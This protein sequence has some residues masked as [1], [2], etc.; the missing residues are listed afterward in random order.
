MGLL[1]FLGKKNKDSVKPSSSSA[2]HS[3]SQ[4][5]EPIRRPTSLRE[6]KITKASKEPL[7]VSDTQ[8]IKK[9]IKV[10]RKS[11][12]VELKF[13]CPIRN[14]K[15]FCHS[16]LIDKLGDLTKFII[17]SLYKG[18]TVDEICALTQMGSTT[19]NEELDYLIRGGII[20]D[21]KKTLTKL[22][23]QYG[24]LLKKFSEMSGGIDI[25]FN[26]FADEFES[27]DED[28]Y[29]SEVEHKYILQ[30]HFIPTLTRNDNYSNSLEFAKKQIESDMPF[31][32]EIKNSLY[33]TVEIGKKVLKYKP[34]YL[35]DFSRGLSE[36]KGS[37]VKIY[38]PC[39]KISCIPRYSWV[40]NYRDV[41]SR[42]SGIDETYDDLLSE[43]AKLLIKTVKEEE[44]AKSITLDINTITGRSVQ[45]SCELVES[46]NE[47]DAFVLEI[48]Q[49][50]LVLDEEVCKGIYLHELNREH[51]YQ[52]QY[53]PYSRME[54]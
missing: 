52:V 2:S 25:S 23:E 13:Y 50:K 35:R 9:N 20:N 27:I 41:I 33:A 37:C 28:H 38:I 47:P 54:V 34:V 5:R 17:S 1:D 24:L 16:V 19:I 49:V 39:D 45:Q 40:D 3:Y 31:C 22:G 46:P 21:D 12:E 36:D 32:Q 51:M 26:V 15:I 29:V 14:A 4:K 53:F 11:E 43:K 44:L 18:Q 6:T 7:K 8:E 10:R 42:I 48:H 30:G